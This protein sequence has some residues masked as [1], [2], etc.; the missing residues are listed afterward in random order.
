MDAAQYELARRLWH[1][2]ISAN[3]IADAC[4]VNYYDITTTAYLNRVDFPKR[5]GHTRI[6]TSVQTLMERMRD[7][8][9]TYQQIADAIG[10]HVNTVA[11]HLRDYG[12]NS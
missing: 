9:M 1:Y 3:K 10:C 5:R 12:G 6:D 2:G 4:G 8:G 11:K 7:G